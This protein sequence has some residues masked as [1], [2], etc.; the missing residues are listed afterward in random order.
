MAERDPHDGGDDEG[1]PG[2]IERIPNDRR[3]VAEDHLLPG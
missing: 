1:D 2:D 3:P